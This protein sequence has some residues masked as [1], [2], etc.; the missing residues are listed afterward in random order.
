[1]IVQ[2]VTNAAHP[3]TNVLSGKGTATPMLT[4]LEDWCV[5]KTIVLAVDTELQMTVAEH[6]LE[7]G[8]TIGIMTLTSDVQRGNTFHTCTAF[9]TMAERTEDSSLPAA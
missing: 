5:V 8:P 1:M 3:L 2:H 9:I 4:V 6:L 7:D